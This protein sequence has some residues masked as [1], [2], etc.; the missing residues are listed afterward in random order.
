MASY[1]YWHSS[2]RISPAWF[3]HFGGLG[4]VTC[5]GTLFELYKKKKKQQ[6]GGDCRIMAEAGGWSQELRRASER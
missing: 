6:G 5:P 4:N 3:H 2:D 1:I